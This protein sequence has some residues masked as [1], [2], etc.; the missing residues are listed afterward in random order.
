MQGKLREYASI[1]N[2]SFI[3]L[4]L[5]FLS[6]RFFCFPAN[7]RKKDD[8]GCHLFRQKQIMYSSGGGGGGGRT[9]IMSAN[10]RHLVQIISC[11][12]NTY[13]QHIHHLEYYANKSKLMQW[14]FEGK[15]STKYIRTTTA[16][17]RL[18][19]VPMPN[20]IRGGA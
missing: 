15:P 3:F 13:S 20:N 17:L 1:Y 5:V 2:M 9:K 11:K 12:T 7:R 19:I 6:S 16:V 4:D 14:C 18:P 10:R 8:V